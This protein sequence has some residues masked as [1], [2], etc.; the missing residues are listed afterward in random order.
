MTVAAERDAVVRATPSAWGVG[1]AAARLHAR[2]VV[3]DLTLPWEWNF[4]E[5]RE[6]TLPRFAR[7]GTSFVSLTVAGDREDLEESVR[8]VAA[9]RRRFLGHPE[10]YVLAGSVADIRRAKAE[11]KLAVAFNLQGTNPLNGDVSMV[12]LYYDLGVR[13]MLMAYNAKNRVGDGCHERTD[14][15]LSRFGVSVVQEMNRVGMLVDCSHTGYRTSMDVFEVSS[16]PVIFSHANAKAVHEHD[17]NLRD[18][19][20]D[21][22]ARSG[23]VIGVVGFGPILSKGPDG[24]EGMFR[25]IDYIA[26]R[27]GPRHVAIGLDFVYFEQTMYQLFGN[28]PGLYARGYTPPPWHFVPP[29]AL[30]Q[31]T[32]TMLRHGYP[33]EVVLGVLGENFLRVAQAVWK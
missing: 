8:T 31:L 17:R 13:H 27:V 15:G 19:Q 33:D 30:P 1:E 2:A 16:A 10:Q 11:G 23:G 26:N 32:E 21:A 3:C 9:E 18:E 5:N 12:S 29:E 4:T 22:C 14:G 24:A 28:R 6:E 20:I 7:A 25:H